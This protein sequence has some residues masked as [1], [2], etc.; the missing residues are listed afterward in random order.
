V[1]AFYHDVLGSFIDGERIVYR[2]KALAIEIGRPGALRIHGIL[3][4][5]G[6]VKDANPGGILDPA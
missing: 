5:S 6:T 4:R 1:R 3:D 2:K